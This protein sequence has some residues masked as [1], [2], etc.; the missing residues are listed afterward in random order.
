MTGRIVRSMSEIANSL[1]NIIIPRVCAVCGTAL[2][3]GEDVMCLGCRAKMPVTGQYLRQPNDIH[4]RLISLRAPLCK[5]TSYFLYHRDNPYAKLI[6]DTKYHGRPKIGRKL[7]AEH[8]RQL[9]RTSFFDGIDSLVPIPLHP[10]KYLR[11]TYNQSEEIAKGISAATSLPILTNL[12]TARYH[13]TQTRK[14]ATDRKLNAAG[15]FKVHH[16]EELTG[17]HIL[18]VDDVITTGATMLEAMEIIKATCPSVKLSVFSLA[19]TSNS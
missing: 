9:L 3:G 2:V 18:L 19:L 1:L 6:H 13:S 16:P 15:S 8:C 14:S 7:A 17:R 11:R 12:K 5:A 4:E 10:L